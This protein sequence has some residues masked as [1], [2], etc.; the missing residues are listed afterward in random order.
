MTLDLSVEVPAAPRLRVDALAEVDHLRARIR[1][2]GNRAANP[3]SAVA[4]DRRIGI[5][6]G[7]LMCRHQLT[8][9]HAFAMLKTHSQRCNVKVREL[10]ESVICT[11]TLRAVP[12]AEQWPP[13][14]R[15]SG[16]SRTRG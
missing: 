8:A 15:R 13:P 4:S 9:D 6:V 5:A 14:L 2:A 1:S 11:G 7:I 10:A 3:E 16:R 12:G